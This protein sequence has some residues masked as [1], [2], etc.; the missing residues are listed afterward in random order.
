MV[1]PTPAVRIAEDRFE[2]SVGLKAFVGRN[3]SGLSMNVEMARLAM[4]PLFL[5][6][7]GH[8]PNSLG[9]LRASSARKG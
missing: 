7:F 5:R 9:L 8:C 4:R 3:A 1:L 6:P 2:V